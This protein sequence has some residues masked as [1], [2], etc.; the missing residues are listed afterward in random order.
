MIDL[1]QLA[2]DYFATFSRKDLAGLALMFHTDVSLFDWEISAEGIHDVLEA[3][4]KM[5]KSIL[6]HPKIKLSE[7]WQG[8][9]LGTLSQDGNNK[10]VNII[11][12]TDNIDCNNDKYVLVS[13]EYV[14]EYVEIELFTTIG[15][16]VFEKYSIKKSDIIDEYN[17]I[18]KDSDRIHNDNYP[19]NLASKKF[20]SIWNYI[21]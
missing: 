4:K 16:Y 3:N 10:K 12:D 18:L 2:T 14:E 17:I 21:S 20:D 9:K 6:S 5:L 13:N 1:K 8:F 15:L 7:D 11:K 19:S